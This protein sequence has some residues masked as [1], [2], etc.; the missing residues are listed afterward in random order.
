[1]NSAL[2]VMRR[3]IGAVG[4][5]AVRLRSVVLVSHRGVM[6]SRKIG[7]RSGYPGDGDGLG[8]KARKLGL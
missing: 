1:M 2:T 3:F 8:E 6:H 7:S 4:A 5:L